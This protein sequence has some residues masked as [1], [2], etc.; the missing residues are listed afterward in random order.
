MTALERSVLDAAENLARS[1]GHEPW[2]AFRGCDCGA[3]GEQKDALEDFDR[4]RQ[5]LR[6]E[7]KDG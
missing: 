3:V 6:E 5:K 7:E 4:E 2:C 1:K